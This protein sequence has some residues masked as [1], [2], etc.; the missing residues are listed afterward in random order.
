M[1][2]LGEESTISPNGTDY[3]VYTNDRLKMFKIKPILFPTEE[4]NRIKFNCRILKECVK[5]DIARELVKDSDEKTLVFFGRATENANSKGKHF[6]L[7]ET[8]KSN[9]VSLLIN[10]NFVFFVFLYF[11]DTLNARIKN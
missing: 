1:N 5:H 3:G 2:T 8:K 4:M 11:L 9:F 10:Y 6:F 7:K